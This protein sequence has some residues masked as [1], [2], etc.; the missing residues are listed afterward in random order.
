MTETLSTLYASRDEACERLMAQI[1]A[2]N[3]DS[4]IVDEIVAIDEAINALR[5]AH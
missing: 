1:V 2:G 3:D 5:V 4:A